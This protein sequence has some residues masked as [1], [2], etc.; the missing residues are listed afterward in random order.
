MNEFWTAEAGPHI[1]TQWV[2]IPDGAT[3][4]LEPCAEVRMQKDAALVFGHA[5]G[6]GVTTLG[7]EG[8]PDRPI[9]FRT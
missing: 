8:E 5:N 6:N 3:L 2:S 1:V 9:C 4:S 7:A